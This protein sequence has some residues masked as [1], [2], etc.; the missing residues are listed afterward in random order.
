MGGKASA[1]A[2]AVAQEINLCS[3]LQLRN[4]ACHRLFNVSK[5]KVSTQNN[6][7]PM[8]QLWKQVRDKIEFH[9]SDDDDVHLEAYIISSMD[10]STRR[11][12]ESHFY[13]IRFQD[14]NH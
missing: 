2:T 6:T 9:D 13:G 3:H 4:V 12:L 10:C 8:N 7:H 14:I 5:I 1:A 11:S